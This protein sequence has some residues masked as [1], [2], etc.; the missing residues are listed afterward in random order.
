MAWHEGAIRALSLSC[1]G[2][3][4]KNLA[5]TLCVLSSTNLTRT[6]CVLSSTNLQLSNTCVQLLPLDLIHFVSRYAVCSQ[7]P[8]I[9]V[10]YSSVIISFRLW[11]C[12]IFGCN[13]APS[14][15]GRHFGPGCRPVI[16]ETQIIIIGSWCA[17]NS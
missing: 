8:P 17:A 5:R 1:S 14:P 4:R 9:S 15:G 16:I 6:L 2:K 11:V 3:P 7:S 13:L 10:S 12:M